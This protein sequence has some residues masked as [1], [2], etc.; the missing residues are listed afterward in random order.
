MLALGDQPAVRP[1]TLRALLRAWRET[2]APLVWPVHGG[3]RG[4]PVVFDA[5]CAPDILALPADATLKTYVVQREHEAV[6]VAVQDAGVLADVDT[7]DDYERALRLWRD[8]D[9]HILPT[10]AE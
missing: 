10:K 4:H 2:K 7:P 6:A 1:D 8:N 9:Q 5:R 3:R